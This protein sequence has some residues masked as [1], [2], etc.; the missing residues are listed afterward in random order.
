MFGSQIAALKFS[1]RA[2]AR[3]AAWNAVGGLLILVG[4]IFFGIAIFVVLEYAVGLLG[5]LVIMGLLFILFGT[6][7]RAM[8]RYPPRVVTQPAAAPAP[9]PA[10]GQPFNAATVINAV[11]MGIAAGRALRRR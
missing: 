6:V 11:I 3:R 7:A 1:L 9:G 5:A 2:N 8:S 4:L 10:Y